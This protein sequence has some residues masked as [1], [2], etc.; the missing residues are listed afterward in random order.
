MIFLLCPFFLFHLPH[1][2]WKPVLFLVLWNKKVSDF[3]FQLNWIQRKGLRQSLV[4]YAFAWQF[5]QRDSC[6]WRSTWRRQRLRQ[7][8]AA[9]RSRLWAELCLWLH[10]RA[11]ATPPA[12]TIRTTSRT[13]CVDSGTPTC[14]PPPRRRTCRRC[15][16]GSSG[17]ARSTRW[18]RRRRPL[19]AP[20]SSTRAATRPFGRSRRRCS[21][22][23]LSAMCRSRAGTRRLG[24]CWSSCGTTNP[25]GTSATNT[26][27][28]RCCRH[29]RCWSPEGETST[30]RH[31]LR[32]P[33]ASPCRT[34]RCTQ[35]DI[36]TIQTDFSPAFLH[37][38]LS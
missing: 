14:S 38:R 28:S 13:C 31:A 9:T 18:R 4:A 25:C 32:S 15:D 3:V 6:Y 23:S 10:F 20:S 37:T 35:S 30:G 8:G 16:T 17:G 27:P 21:G 24:A 11:G 34:A 1:S 26:H 33:T 7:P 19:A 5:W 36:C 29:R 22:P 12:N 2:T